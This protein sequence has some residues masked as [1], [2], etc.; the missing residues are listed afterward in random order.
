MSR[1]APE[2]GYAQ[3]KTALVNRLHRIESQVHSTTTC[4]T[5]F[6]G[7]YASGDA[8]EMAQKTTELLEAVQR[9]ARTR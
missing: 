5:A 4:G 1:T 2:P 3:D 8:D 7:A 9:F 6:A